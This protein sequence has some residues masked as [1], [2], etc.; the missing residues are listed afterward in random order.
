LVLFRLNREAIR[1]FDILKAE[2]GPRSGPRLMA[3]AIDLLLVRYHKELSPFQ[4]SS[5]SP[6]WVSFENLKPAEKTEPRRSNAEILHKS[7][8]QPR[9]YALK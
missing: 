2:Q 5:F 3:E 7:K 8:Q 4:P 1:A 9:K 6:K